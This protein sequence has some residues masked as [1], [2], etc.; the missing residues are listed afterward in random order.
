[1]SAEPPSA[2]GERITGVLER[3]VFQNEETA[4]CIGE[5]RVEK[6]REIVS[7][8][9]L[10][11]GVE[12]GET[13]DLSGRW[14][15]HRE[16]GRQ[17]MV[18]GFR[19][20]LPSSV[21]GIRRY[22]GSGLV[23]GV[24]KTYAA[25]IVEHFGADTLRVLEEESGR[26]REVE[27]IGPKRAR[28]IKAA[29]DAQRAKREVMLFLQ[30]YGV[31][32]HHCRRIL[33]HYGSGAKALLQENPYE[34]ARVIEGIG[35]KTADRIA[36]NL[37]FARTAPERV[38]AGLVYVLQS[39]EDEGHTA[40]ERTT[41]L[42]EAA[43]LLDA[44]VPALEGRLTS[45]VEASIIREVSPDLFQLPATERAET[46]IAGELRRLSKNG[47][48]LPAIR[49][50]AALA[51]AQERAGFS[52][53]EEQAEAIRQAL[54]HKVSILTGGPGTGKTTIL[55][56]LTA[57][58]RAKEVKIVL[59]SP[60]GRAAQR[61]AE[62]C[63]RPA[64]TLH[65][66]LH[67]DPAAGGFQFNSRH[68]LS[69]DVFILD[70]C[71]MLDT[72][73]A[74]AFFAALPSMA[75]L[76]LV[77]DAD[78]LPSVGPGNVLRDLIAS[79]RIPVTHLSRIFRQDEE[80]SI[81]AVAH[82]IL[83]GQGA[84]PPLV[85]SPKDLDA[86]RDIQFFELTESGACVE[87]VARLCKN[88]IPAQWGK[89]TEFQVLAPMHKG[90]VGIQNLNRV[91]QASL[92]PPPAGTRP[93]PPEARLPFRAGDR[94][95]QTRNNYEKKVFNG[96]LGTIQSVEADGGLL[97]RFDRDTVAYEKEAAS[98][99]THA[100]AIS[101]HKAQGSEFPIVV[102]PLMRAHFLLLQ[103]N[104]LYTA[105]TRAKKKVI[106]VGDPGAYAMAV[107]NTGGTTRITALPAKLLD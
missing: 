72:R 38:D 63:Q 18:E 97:V 50:E 60:T 16:Y 100:Y 70:E 23:P 77:G 20:R 35:F 46:T 53:A 3:V 62:S 86:S 83:A 13:L 2:G 79:G 48:A 24:G 32:L 71:S 17:F 25:K 51:W 84:P 26:L 67:F 93:L 61:L 81:V 99:L 55:R 103:R 27:G 96:D 5:L 91:L 85:R 47:S 45:L 12:C 44:E 94:V 73:L 22:L 66:L 30:T 89:E 90:I 80:S 4:F 95:L 52:F 74:A 54:R 10:L 78:Q 39:L 76:V 33:Q 105:I 21:H 65:R 37:G 41:L 14:Q 98:E 75:H 102:L 7:I 28:E 58:L 92:N 19:S 43:R 34:I 57:I 104:L 49:I 29:W 56:S 107:G 64:S 40:F 68:P 11:P 8:K 59:A 88:W 87:A 42:D 82:R 9:G 69:G 101:V 6:T 15:M 1:M 31:G 106:M 36:L